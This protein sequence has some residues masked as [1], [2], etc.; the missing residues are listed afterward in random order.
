MKKIVLL[1]VLFVISILSQSCSIAND[2]VTCFDNPV[3]YENKQETSFKIIEVFDDGALA[4]EASV[5]IG[6]IVTYSGKTVLI[7]GKNFYDSQIVTVKNPFIYGTIHLFSY[8]I[9]PI[10]VPIIYGDIKQ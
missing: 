5:T 9:G 10:T 4:V 7:V 3:S 2:S 6:K 8:K 1:S